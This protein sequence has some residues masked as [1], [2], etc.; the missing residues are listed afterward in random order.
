MYFLLWFDGLPA[1]SWKLIPGAILPVPTSIL[2]ANVGCD[3]LSI[4]LVYRLLGLCTSWL[5]RICFGLLFAASHI[6]VGVTVGGMEANLFMTLCLTAAYLVSRGAI[7]SGLI[8]AASAC[9]LRPEGLMLIGLIVLWISRT[10]LTQ[11]TLRAAGVALLIL[12]ILAGVVAAM[13][14]S[15]ITQSVAT[16]AGQHS[17][18]VGVLRQLV[19]PDSVSI[20]ILPFAMWVSSGSGRTTAS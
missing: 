2:A 1:R 11:A 6:L 20:A 16:K 7:G 17:S 19:W 4:Y 9:W 15:I 12:A 10:K 13:Y 8:V 14:G 3:L 5:I 18:V